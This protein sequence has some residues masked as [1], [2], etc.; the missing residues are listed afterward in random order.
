MIR[1]VLAALLLAFP[2]LL[3]GCSQE[4][5]TA[6][7]AAPPAKAAPVQ[8][9]QAAAPKP[10]APEEPLP[11]LAPALLDPA[12]ATL[13]APADFT[14]KLETTQ[15]DILIDV[16]RDWSPNGADRFYNLV[17]IGYF[18]DI[19][20]FRVIS[21]FMAQ[22]GIH[23]DPRVNEQWREA[24]IQDDPVKQSNTR[25]MVTFAMSSQPNSRTTQFF[26]SFKDNSNLDGMGFAPF[27]QVRDMGAVDK[28]FSGYGEGAPR[29][30]GPNQGKVQM[31]GNP[32]LRAE[33]P[34]LD[35]IVK[36]SLVE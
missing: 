32:Y 33:F 14:V 15:G 24:N 31:V 21:G 6:N 7:P 25:G 23:G 19:A 2:V 13:Q 20:F 12:G 34:K 9:A 18:E 4:Q 28:L 11:A 35:Y 10:A 17:K 36:A 3:T 27:G 1:R 5:P 8:A 30:R 22:V 29:G 26:I 16:H